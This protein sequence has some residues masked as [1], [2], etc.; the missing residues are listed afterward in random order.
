MLGQLEDQIRR[1]IEEKPNSSAGDLKDCIDKLTLLPPSDEQLNLVERLLLGEIVPNNALTSGED[2]A[3]LEYS[4]WARMINL[5]F[6]NERLTYSIVKDSIWRAH[7]VVYCLGKR[8]A[9]AH[10][11][12]FSAYM[13][14]RF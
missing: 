2:I 8:Q 13:D 9:N 11:T 1:I 3:F 6:E 12:H 7:R 5:L 14:Q 4:G 10:L